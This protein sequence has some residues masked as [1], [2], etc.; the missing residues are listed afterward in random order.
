MCNHSNYN[1]RK[2]KSFFKTFQVLVDGDD[3]ILSVPA[4]VFESYERLMLCIA[5]PIPATSTTQ[6]VFIQ[7]GTTRYPLTTTAGTAVNSFQLKCR[8][9][10]PIIAIP[11][12]AGFVISERYLSYNSPITAEATPDTPTTGA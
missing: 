4:R 2:C 3:V 8:K 5:Q 7:S 12:P 9:A 6:A 11:T 1:C 10:Y